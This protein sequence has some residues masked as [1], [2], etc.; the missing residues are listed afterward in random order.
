MQQA[1]IFFEARLV[2]GRQRIR[3]SGTTGDHLVNFAECA[4]QNQIE[5]IRYR[6]LLSLVITTNFKGFREFTK[7]MDN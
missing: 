6:N 7:R 1:N 4:V 3:I 2:R 5:F